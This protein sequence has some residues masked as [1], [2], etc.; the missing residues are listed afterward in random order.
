VA[1]KIGWAE[2]PTDGVD[3]LYREQ[4]VS[5]IRLA[6]L[7]TGDRATAEDVVQDAFLSLCRRWPG[8]NDPGNAVSYLR[9]SV[10]NGCRSV[11]RSRRIAWLRRPPHDPPVW[12]AEAAAI[13]G[14]DRREVLA[15]VAALPHRQREILALRFYLDMSYDEIAAALKIS[16]GTVSSTMSR[17]IATL[18]DQL[19]PQKE[20]Q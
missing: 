3:E 7:L 15:A 18:A 17:A 1:V 12:S 19:G 9:T 6:L 2:P 4:A 8:L 14:E 5:M 20:N 16:R 13:N 10:V 11:H